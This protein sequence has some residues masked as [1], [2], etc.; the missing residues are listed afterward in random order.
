MI[1]YFPKWYKIALI[2]WAIFVLPGVI[3]ALA[4]D[5]RAALFGY[6]VNISLSNPIDFF[7]D[8]I[9]K[10]VVFFPIVGVWLWFKNPHSR[11]Q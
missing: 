8:I 6:I 10:I 3:L 5:W 2:I 9:T 4:T 11:K 7:G 1:G